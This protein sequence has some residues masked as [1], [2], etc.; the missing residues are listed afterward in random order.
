MSP[1]AP[2]LDLPEA[3]E[4]QLWQHARRVWPQECV[5]MLGGRRAGGG[6]QA[7]ALYPLLNVAASSEREYLAGAAGVLRAWKAM[8]EE[9]LELAAIY[10]SHPRGPAQFSRSDQQ[11]A[12]YDVPYLIADVVSGQLGAFLLPQGVVCELRLGGD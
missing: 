7:R 10:H 11:Q 6:W 2:W 1:S 8:R 4:R 9:G 3:L 5:G 12:A